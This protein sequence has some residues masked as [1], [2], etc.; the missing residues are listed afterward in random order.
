MKSLVAEPIAVGQLRERRKYTR[1]TLP[2]ALLPET[3]SMIRLVMTRKIAH[4][5]E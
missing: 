2:T 1:A 3:P 5:I 4:L